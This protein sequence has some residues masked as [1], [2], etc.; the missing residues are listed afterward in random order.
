M[1]RRRKRTAAGLLAA[2]IIAV[3]VAVL[4]GREKVF[5]VSHRAKEVPAL[6]E[7]ETYSVATVIDGDSLRLTNGAEVRLVGIDAPDKKEGM[8][9]ADEA[10]QFAKELLEGRQIKL[11]FDR[12]KTD[13]YDRFLAYVLY[14]DGEGEKVANIEIVR[15]GCAYAYSFKPN[16]AREKEIIA[17]QKEARQKVLGVWKR[18]VKKEKEYI[19]DWGANFGLTHKPWCKRIGGGGRI[20]KVKTRE[21]GFDMG[22]P[23]CRTC[24]P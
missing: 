1:R 6:S 10:R 16:I 23:P 22:A 18:Q 17:A 4:A 14:R 8:F 20:Q 3:L 15:A 5:R 9:Y 21:E 12:E 11:L 13:R 2:V 24:Q 7:S 19:V